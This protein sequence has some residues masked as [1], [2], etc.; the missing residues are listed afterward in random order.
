M[1]KTSAKVLPFQPTKP[2]RRPFS[3]RTPMGERSDVWIHVVHTTDPRKALQDRVGIVPEG[4]VQFSRILVAIYQPPE[5]DRVG[6]ILVTQKIKKE[7]LNE[8][9][10]QGKVGLIVAKGPQAYV[11]DEATKFHGTC[12]EVGDWVWFQP[13]HGVGCNVNEVFCRILNE[14]DI[15][16][17]IPHPDYVW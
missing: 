10:W 7:D 16:G 15:I 11:D 14:R 8:N 9:L 1:A 5:I 13:S 2:I 12:N 3:V 6:S 17:T 4:V